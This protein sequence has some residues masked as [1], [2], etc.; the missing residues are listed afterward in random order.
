MRKTEKF[1]VQ[2]LAEMKDFD[3]NH[4]S[5]KWLSSFEKPR[6]KVKNL[7]V[8]LKLKKRVP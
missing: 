3:T 7:G 4:Q 2:E 6:P 5:E 8:F 1:T